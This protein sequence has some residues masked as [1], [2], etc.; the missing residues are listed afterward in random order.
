MKKRKSPIRIKPEYWGLLIGAT[1]L[2]LA[3]II[4]EL[5]SFFWRSPTPALFFF[6]SFIWWMSKGIIPPVGAS[7]FLIATY[8]I[9]FPT[10]I[11][12]VMKNTKGYSKWIVLALGIAF[13]IGTFWVLGMS[14]LHQHAPEFDLEIPTH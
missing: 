14:H 3:Q 4:P 11:A 7:L 13:F 12:H 10:L 1:L 9:G 5:N 6:G 8:T 2:F